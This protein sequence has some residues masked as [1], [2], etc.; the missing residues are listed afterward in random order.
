MNAKINFDA[1]VQH[2][3]ETTQEWAYRALRYVIMSGQ[4]TPG[5][6]LTI[7]GL[8]ADMDVSAMPIREALRR[9][10]SEGALELKSNRRI[11]VPKLTPA[12]LAELLELRVIV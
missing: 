10:T 6:A 11:M 2:D 1:I 3:G 4:I 5:R 9:L 8:A 12:R 7:R